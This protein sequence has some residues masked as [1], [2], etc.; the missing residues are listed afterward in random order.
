MKDANREVME[1]A[2]AS[3]ERLWAE[4]LTQIE[5]YAADLTKEGAR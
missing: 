1:A 4:R 5:R 3:A 2:I